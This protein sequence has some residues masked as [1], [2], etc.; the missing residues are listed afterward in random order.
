MTIQI[1]SL[2]LADMVQGAGPLY[3]SI[4]DALARAIESGAA[5]PGSRLPTQRALAGRLGVTVGTVTRAYAEA[6]RRGLVR[7]EVGRGTFI[8][9]DSRFQPPSGTRFVLHDFPA[10]DIDL[11]VNT[12]PP[13]G[14]VNAMAETLQLLEDTWAAPSNG[15]GSF[16]LSAAQRLAV[17][18]NLAAKAKKA[19]DSG[20]LDR[21]L[22]ILKVLRRIQGRRARPALRPHGHWSAI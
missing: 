1:D 18:H 20:S 13:L 17:V 8:R 16:G 7:G 22:G 12:T 14:A 15:L 2:P 9:S 10:Q 19:G 3:R 4:A 11:S 21:L 6:E 5:K